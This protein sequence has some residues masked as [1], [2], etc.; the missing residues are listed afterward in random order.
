MSDEGGTADAG[1]TADPTDATPTD[2]DEPAAS[3]GKRGADTGGRLSA[4]GDFLFIWGLAAALVTGLYALGDGLP[5]VLLLGGIAAVAS[6]GAVA[7][8]FADPDFRPS[9]GLYAVVT[10]SSAAGALLA[11][12]FAEALITASGLA[13]VALANAGRVV[14]VGYR[15]EDSLLDPLTGDEDGEAEAETAAENSEA[16]TAAENSR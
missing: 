10:L 16:E 13:V 9:T 2:A 4:E 11:Y 3:G 14:E 8:D 5:T 6:L 12:V 7:A 15:N 1:T